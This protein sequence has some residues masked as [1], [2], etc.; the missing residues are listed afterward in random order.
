MRVISQSGMVDIPYESSV[1]TCIDGIIRARN[2]PDTYIMA[3]YQDPGNAGLAL[4]LM[5]LGN[6]T[7]QREYRFFEEIGA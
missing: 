4:H 6:R 3:E 2:G 5:R 7:N 1:I